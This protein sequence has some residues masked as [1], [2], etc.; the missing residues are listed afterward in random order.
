MVLELLSSGNLSVNI[1]GIVRS[2]HLHIQYTPD[3]PFDIWY[4]R[5]PAD[6]LLI[7]SS[8]NRE[9]KIIEIFY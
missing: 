6:R 9:A 3:Y 4:A 5:N 2:A 1:T 8:P 7:S